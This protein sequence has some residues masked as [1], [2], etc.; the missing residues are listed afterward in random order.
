[1]CDKI[2]LPRGGTTAP[3]SLKEMHSRDFTNN[4][5]YWSGK[6]GARDRGGRLLRA[7]LDNVRPCRVPLR[8]VLQ[9]VRP[10]P[11]VPS[12]AP[13]EGLVPSESPLVSSRRREWAMR[14]QAARPEPVRLEPTCGQWGLK[15]DGQART[16]PLLAQR[17]TRQSQEILSPGHARN[18]APVSRRRAG[19]V[20]SRPS[21]FGAG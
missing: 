6:T 18:W 17:D 14:A 16:R 13:R 1:M 21:P 8:I 2:V 10:G 7:K 11:P 5:D 20:T 9:G 15:P 4:L 3:Q 19:T 12:P